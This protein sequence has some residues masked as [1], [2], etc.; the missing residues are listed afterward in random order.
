MTYEF[1]DIFGM[2]YM[3][4]KLEGARGYHA[5]KHLLIDEMQD[6]APIQYVVLTKLFPCK[7]TILGDTSQSVT[8][9]S[10]TPHEKIQEIF[11]A[12]RLVKLNKSYRSS[13]EITRFA[14]QILPN[15]ELEA[16]E[17]H[18]KE[19]EVISCV[20]DAQE[21][22]VILGY[23]Q[24]F[25]QAEHGS[26]GIICK[27][28]ST[29]VQLHSTVAEHTECNLLSP[30]SV[31]FVHGIQI[32]SAHMS[33]GLEFDVVVIPFAQEKVY[34]TETDKHLFYIACTRAMHELYVKFT[35]KKTTFLPS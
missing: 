18:G 24:E 32:A 10:S 2:A 30:D 17:R 12:A 31:S 25:K 27:T 22:E 4:T 34:S 19:P 26:M 16:V 23:I 13:F 3:K 14:Q 8:T 9:Y 6:Y 7:K 1:L 15:A 5:V 35:K 21:L 29:A 33:K 28:H 20:S 11:P